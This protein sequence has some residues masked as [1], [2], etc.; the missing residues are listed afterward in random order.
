MGTILPD[1]CFGGTCPDGG[2]PIGGMTHLRSVFTAV[3]ILDGGKDADRG[4]I[5][6]LERDKE[7]FAIRIFDTDG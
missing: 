4:L 5:A 2:V 1:A 7:A 3:V 6:L